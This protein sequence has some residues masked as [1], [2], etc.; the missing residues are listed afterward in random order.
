M[1]KKFLDLGKQPIA[2]GFLKN[3]TDEFFFNLSVG[4]DEK[5]KLVSLME[6]VS[7]EKMFNDSY[8]YHA[9]QSKTMKKHFAETAFNLKKTLNPKTVM[10]I[11]SND[12]VFIKNFSKKNTIAVEPCENF[13]KKTNNDG[14][15]TYPSFWDIELAKQIVKNDGKQDLVFSAN[16]M[17]HIPDILNAFES[18]KLLLS[19]SGV[20]VFE[21]PSLL[22]MIERGSYDQIYD[23]HAHIFSVTALQNLL[24]KIG[25]EIFKV[26]QLDVHGGSNRIYASHASSRQIDSSVTHSLKEEESSGLDK[27]DTY[28]KFAE[29]VKQSKDE[30]LKILSFYKSQGCK[31]VSYGATSKSTTIFNYCGITQDLIDYI[32]DTTPSKQG[33]LSP[34]VNIPVVS[35]EQ[36]FDNSVDVAF[37]GAWNFKKEI[38]EKE[39]K[40]LQN[41]GLFLTHV[42]HIK[43]IKHV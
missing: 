38:L 33:K 17:C 13:A 40:F 29:S 2:N 26:E 23:E 24:K 19:E 20:F 31:I 16:C 42:P 4:F 34:G 12:G 32:V 37:L 30:L 1:K 41:G 15:K 35:P 18:V 36:G 7:L 6:F 3:K 8:V 43:E 11:G 25:L 39:K 9:S 5:T 10:E 21:D 27:F 22:K 14:Y 28:L